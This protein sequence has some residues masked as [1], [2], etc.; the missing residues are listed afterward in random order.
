M[1]S[2]FGRRGRQVLFLVVV[3]MTFGHSAQF[4]RADESRGRV[5]IPGLESS[6]LDN[7]LQGLVLLEELNCVAC[8]A[9]EV[10][11]LP[12]S[13]RRG[14]KKIQAAQ[15][16]PAGWNKIKLTYIHAGQE[17][18]DYL[19]TTMP[20]FGEANVGQLVDLFAKVDSL[21]DVAFDEIKDIERHKAAGHQLVGV[22]GFSCIACHDF[23]G[24]KASGPGAMDI[25]HS[26]N[27][28]KKSWFY[29]F[30]SSPQTP[31]VFPPSATTTSPSRRAFPFI[32]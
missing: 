30:L 20:Q 1:I 21:E 7:T 26:T 24:Q 29:L 8:H 19:A 28:L 5:A 23:N 11:D 9:M 31:A 22:T 4:S 27:R 16:L 15:K 6:Q 17:Q 18:R 32:A 14:V 2:R 13:S 10:A 3:C 12:P 25:I